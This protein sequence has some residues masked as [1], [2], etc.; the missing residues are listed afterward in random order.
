MVVRVCVYVCV[1]MLVCLVYRFVHV[2]TSILAH[3]ETRG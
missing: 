2:C 3:T 1:L